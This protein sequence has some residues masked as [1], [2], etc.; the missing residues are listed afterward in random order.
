[1]VFI[2][3]LIANVLLF[4][5]NSNNNQNIECDDEIISFYDD[6]TFS[7]EITKND[8]KYYGYYSTGIK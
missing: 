6:Q 3:C 5:N 2:M 8:I 7:W 4:K 1:M